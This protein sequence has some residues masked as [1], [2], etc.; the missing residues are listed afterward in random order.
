[1]SATAA[2]PLK[3]QCPH[4]RTKLDL[5]E[6]EPFS[7]IS[8]PKCDA[9][10]VV[11]QWFQS[12]LLEEILL[13]APGLRVYRALDPTLDRESCV[14]QLW[15]P[16]APSPPAD[17]HSSPYEE[18]TLEEFLAVFRQ[19]S[20]LLHPN[21]VPV[22]SCGSL[23]GLVYAVTQYVN[24]QA[25]NQAFPTEAPD[26]PD[27]LQ[28]FKAACEALSYAAEKGVCHGHL[29][30]ENM[31][32]DQDGILRL[33]D[34]GVARAIGKDFSDNPYL[35]P[36]FGA[37]Q[38]AAS[39]SGDIFSLGVCIYE[40]ATGVLPCA[41]KET[42]WRRGEI[43]PSPISAFNP[44]VPKLFSDLILQM[45]SLSAP[46]RPASYET[47]LTICQRLS[48]SP[49]ST[50][51]RQK[52]RSN[53]FKVS[54]P[55]ASRP[56]RL[57]QSPRRAGGKAI[58]ILIV[59]LTL[60]ALLLLALIL[61][62]QY[63]SK[64]LFGV[65][66][67]SE[68]QA[69][70]QILAQAE[71]ES[72]ELDL[73]REEEERVNGLTTGKNFR[74][75]QMAADLLAARPRPADYDFRQVREELTQYMSQLPEE[76]KEQERERIRI[77]ASYKE[78][79]VSK[80]RKLP[81]QPDNYPGLRLRNGKLIKGTLTLFSDEKALK[82]RQNSAAAGV[83]REIPWSEVAL[84]EVLEMSFYY[85]QRSHDQIRGAKVI[86]QKRLQE[87]VDEYLYLI[88]FCDWYQDHAYLD[89]VCRAALTLPDSTL[90]A[91]IR[92]YVPWPAS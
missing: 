6:L 25:L 37:G 76:S 1:M 47:I 62:K 64:S 39:L 42:A 3:V 22:C 72:R 78:Y 56:I 82:L 50:Q 79:L 88:M 85:V 66:L 63:G 65:D 44:A 35:E 86:S 24:G 7:E 54:R 21:I 57:V 71:A 67:E 15:V 51:R 4:C 77:I 49:E 90:S 2:L 14:K 91:R 69:T 58:N 45:L 59:L 29:S 20:L 43:T 74:P 17:D 12:L 33:T 61:H 13:S 73:R 32:L 70:A 36:E 80:M 40:Y 41:G 68:K 52:K 26:W 31:L 30:P 19:T 23:S 34:F 38:S 10:M 89:K 60:L 28:V 16:S 84:S 55:A 18:Q 8:C 46:Q 27:I 53:R 87:V 81:Y 9:S 83:F 92:H 5:S 11:P 48:L 75:W